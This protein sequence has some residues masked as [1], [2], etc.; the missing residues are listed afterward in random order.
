MKWM[1]LYVTR[2]PKVAMHS[3]GE[4]VYWMIEKI[5]LFKNCEQNGRGG[6]FQEMHTHTYKKIV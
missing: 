3:V 5:K 2:I 6:L 1:I 4:M